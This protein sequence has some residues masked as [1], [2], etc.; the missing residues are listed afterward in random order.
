MN[1]NGT[2]GQTS[3]LLVLFVFLWPCL[4][5]STGSRGTYANDALRADQLDQL[6]GNG[7]FAVALGVGLEV[8]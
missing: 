3:V 7:A 6:V 4:P 2:L 8:A 1:N 5:F